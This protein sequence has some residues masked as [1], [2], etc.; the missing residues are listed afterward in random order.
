MLNDKHKCSEQVLRDG[1]EEVEDLLGGVLDRDLQVVVWRTLHSRAARVDLHRQVA[2][3]A[4]LQ[5]RGEARLRLR[6]DAK[7][8]L[9]ELH[10]DV[11]Q[12]DRP[13]VRRLDEHRELPRRVPTQTH[14]ELH[15]V[16]LLGGQDE[17]QRGLC[18]SGSSVSRCRGN[19]EPEQVVERVERDVLRRRRGGCGAGAGGL[20]DGADAEDVVQ[21]EEQ[22][23]LLARLL[24]R[25]HGGV[26]VEGVGVGLGGS[27][28]AGRLPLLAACPAR[29]ARELRDERLRELVVHRGERADVRDEPLA[30]RGAE[31]R[32]GVL[33]RRARRQNDRLG[34]LRVRGEEAPVDEAAVAQV[35]VVALL[36]GELQHLLDQ[37][38][39]LLGLL[40][41]ELDRC[42]EELELD[43]VGLVLEVLEERLEQLGGVLDAVGVLADDPHH[44]RLGVGLVERGEVLA[45]VRDDRLVLVRVAAEDVAD[46]HGRLLDDVVDLGADQLEQHLDAARRG[47]LQLDRAPPDRAHRLA[48][49]LDVHHLGV[50]LELG[51]HLV[52]VVLVGQHDH[53]LQLL[54]LDVDGVVVLA[55][56]DLHLVLEHLRAALDDDVDVAQ[57]DVLDLVL[58]PARQQRDQRRREL[59]AVEVDDVLR[60]DVLQHE[61]DNL[62]GGEH[63]GGVVVVQPRDDA[64]ADVL[65]FLGV[66]RHELGGGVEDAHLPPLGALGQRREQLRDVVR[67]HAEDGLG[68]RL[69]DLGQRRDGVGDDD[70]VRVAAEVLELLDEPLLL[71]HV[72]VDVVELGDTHRGGLAHVRVSVLQREHER[73]GEVFRDVLHTDAPHRPHRERADERVGVGGILL[74]RVDGEDCAVGLAL[75]VVHHVEIHQLL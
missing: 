57:R 35:G 73:L 29:R 26:R 48:D 75:G 16:P 7:R 17:R 70:R 10:R 27:V 34:S 20:G 54:Q 38:A 56:E 40:Q 6:R 46:D 4:R 52:D 58:L 67:V 36:R 69:V 8:V 15:P 30:E 72:R 32:R 14:L 53:D 33:D 24:R 45:Q 28:G 2:A 1:H 66:R 59:L 12:S 71:D 50:V 62:R 22:V 11:V 74:E 47:A 23:G 64:L 65:G 63:D 5:R 41:E 19:A 60:G 9:V 25:L 49:K 18:G 68:R 55:E 21:V 51:Q 44:R 39:A 3:R 31:R 43:G 61:Q 37:R 42:R 13:L